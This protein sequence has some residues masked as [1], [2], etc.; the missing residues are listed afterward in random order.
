MIFNPS[1]WEFLR[2]TNTV[3]PIHMSYYLQNEKIKEVPHAKY[4]GVA[5]DQHL[6]CN[7]HARP[8]RSQQRLTMLR[9]FSSE[10]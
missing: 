9:A 7:E 5:I 6:M 8:D 3:Y 1:K 4:L 2:V 10:T